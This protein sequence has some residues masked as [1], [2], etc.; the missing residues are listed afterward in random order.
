M[1]RMLSAVLLVIGM[2]TA[3]YAVPPNFG[4]KDHGKVFDSG[5][6]RVSDIHEIYYEVSGNPKGK[7]AIVLHGGPGSGMHP[8][9][10]GL[11]N[12]Q[13][14]MVVLFDQRGAGKSKPRYELRENTTQDLVEDIEKLRT[15]LNLGKVMIVGGSWGSTLGLA[16]AE[17]YPENV[18][19]MVL[20]AIYLG[21]PE[22]ESNTYE[23]DGLNKYYPELFEKMVSEVSPGSKSLDKKKL[24]ALLTSDDPA[25]ADKYSRLWTFYEFKITSLN[26]PD[27]MIN[28]ILDKNSGMGRGLALIET[29][30][31]TNKWFLKKDVLMKNS[32]KL[33]D[34]P[35][36][37]VN[38]RYDMMTPPITAYR[39]HKKL[40]NSK[41]CIAEAAGHSDWEIPVAEKM[42]EAIRE[43][44]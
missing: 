27:D 36:A 38:G 23:P 7:P 34:I 29:H 12:P 30:Y 3:A 11:F 10:R 37:L 15:H 9:I 21:T 18:S 5:Y 44:E 17:K 16:Y 41:L 6:L 19:A 24:M 33:K 8:N 2:C 42:L 40:P 13:K 43:F 31:V 25:T 26:A 32:D 35:I 28:G 14:Y 4:F 22:E 39:L 1:K 20:R